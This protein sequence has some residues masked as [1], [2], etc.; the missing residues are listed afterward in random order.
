MSGFK[1]AGSA[2]RFLSLYYAVYNTLNLQRHLVLRHS[3]R[4]LR[5]EAAE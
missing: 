3:L 1:A 4:L 2:Q 5:A